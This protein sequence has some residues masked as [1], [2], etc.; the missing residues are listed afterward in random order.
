MNTIRIIDGHYNEKFTVPDG[1]LISIDGKRYRLRYLNDMNF[2]LIALD[3]EQRDV[4]HISQFGRNI[5]DRGCVVL[6]VDE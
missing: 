4:F 1:G 2:E 6:I 3:F 5:I